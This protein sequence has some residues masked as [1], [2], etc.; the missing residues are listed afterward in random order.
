MDSTVF[1]IF[2]LHFNLSICSFHQH[3]ATTMGRQTMLDSIWSEIGSSICTHYLWNNVLELYEHK[4]NFFISQA[5]SGEGR[6]PYTHIQ[7]Q[8]IYICYKKIWVKVPEHMSSRLTKREKT[9]Q[10]FRAIPDIPIHSHPFP[11]SSIPIHSHSHPFP[12]IR[13][14]FLSIRSHF[15]PIPIYF[16]SIPYPCRAIRSHSQ[17]IPSH[18]QPFSIHSEPFDHSQSIPSHSQPFGHSQSILSRSQPFSHSQSIPSHSNAREWVFSPEIKTL[19]TPLSPTKNQ[20]IWLK[21]SGDIQIFY[22]KATYGPPCIIN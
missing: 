22:R 7:F 16:Q 20:P 13:K 17:P 15:W 1:G 12:A 14:T 2:L 8:I 11:F 5:Y 3:V 19:N 18:S 9:I 6:L 21:Q 10:I 4:M